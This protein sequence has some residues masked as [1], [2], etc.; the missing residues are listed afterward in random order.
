MK[1]IA[2]TAAI[3]A[4]ALATAPARA[5]SEDVTVTYVV[6]PGGAAGVTVPVV[7]QRIGAGGYAFTPES[8]PLRLRI[9]DVNGAGVPWVA[10]Q[11][12]PGQEGETPGA[13]GDGDDATVRGCSTNQFQSL[14]TG[15]VAGTSIAIF[16]RLATTPVQ[17]T[18]SCPQV[19]LGGVLTI[20]LAPQ[21]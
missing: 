20:D 13:C 15:F 5:G 12:G 19:S 16:V 11:E 17:P 21:G 7:G 4:L 10:C 2:A 14:G 18:P 3:L 9:E 6:R 1:K 8:K